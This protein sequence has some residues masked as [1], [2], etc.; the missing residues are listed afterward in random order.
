MSVMTMVEP[1]LQGIELTPGQLA[2]LRALDT[3]YYSRLASDGAG[4]NEDQLLARVR[5]MLHPDQR[6]KFD[7]NRAARRS[8]EAPRGARTERH[9]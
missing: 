5:D 2:E 1:L 4:A 8:D 3:L 9:G 7:R 6:A